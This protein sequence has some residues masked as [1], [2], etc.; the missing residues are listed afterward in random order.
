MARPT[1]YLFCRYLISDE[2]DPVTPDEEWEIL[3]EIKGLD[4]TP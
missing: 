3:Q 2:D 4:C 1:S